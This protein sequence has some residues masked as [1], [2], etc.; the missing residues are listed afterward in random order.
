MKS[1]RTRLLLANYRFR[2]PNS[3]ECPKTE[4]AVPDISNNT[5]M[6]R[7]DGNKTTT[8]TP[9]CVSLTH[10]SHPTK[11]RKKTHP[12]VRSS[13]GTLKSTPVKVEGIIESSPAFL[14]SRSSRKSHH[15]GVENRCS[16]IQFGGM[17]CV[18]DRGLLVLLPVLA[19]AVC[20]S[21]LEAPVLRG[22]SCQVS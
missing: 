21:L 4:L 9:P 18:P 15:G 22:S 7:D 17:C 3:N 20:W 5:I 14:S 1:K 16:V 8:D 10:H 6:L 13:K 2:A 11:R 19:L 12:E